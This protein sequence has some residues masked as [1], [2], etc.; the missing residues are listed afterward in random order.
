LS[1]CTPFSLSFIGFTPQ[2]GTVYLND[3]GQ[4]FIN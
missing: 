4:I 1:D 3:G 2:N